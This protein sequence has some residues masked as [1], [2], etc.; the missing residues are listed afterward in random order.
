MF[1]AIALSIA[2]TLA[3]GPTAAQVCKAVC[4]RPSAAPGGCHHDA[5]PAPNVASDSN[6]DRAAVTVGAFFREEVERRSP[7][8]HASDAVRV[9]SYQVPLLTTNGDAEHQAADGW[10][11]ASRPLN[12]ALRI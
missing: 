3:A 1:H 6:C 4:S 9:S 2:L 8:P 12:T 11:L 7:A 5:S 10:S